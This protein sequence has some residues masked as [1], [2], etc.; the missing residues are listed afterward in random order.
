MSHYKYF[1][2]FCQAKSE[3]LSRRDGRRRPQSGHTDNPI[4]T[5]TQSRQRAGERTR[6]SCYQAPHPNHLSAGEGKEEH[7][8]KAL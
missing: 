7:V 4:A 6:G 1:A 3:A 5:P 2:F 8:H